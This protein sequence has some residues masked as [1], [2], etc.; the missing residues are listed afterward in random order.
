MRGINPTMKKSSFVKPIAVLLAA[1]TVYES[2]TIPL[3]EAATAPQ[4]AVQDTG[5]WNERR[6][7]LRTLE[8]AR[9]DEQLAMLPEALRTAPPS[10]INPPPAWKPSPSRT[11]PS[12]KCRPPAARAPPSLF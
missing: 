10:P 9:S 3:A 12:K 2:V 6:E 11:A 7:H 5:F 4:P 8:A 1:L